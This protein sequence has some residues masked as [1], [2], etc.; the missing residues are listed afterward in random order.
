MLPY[1]SMVSRDVDA[2]D[3]RQ[4]DGRMNLVRTKMTKKK[5]DDGKE[6]ATTFT[7]HRPLHIVIAFALRN[8]CLFIGRR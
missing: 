2:E 5:I 1:R 4:R 7:L 6:V 8:G 3:E